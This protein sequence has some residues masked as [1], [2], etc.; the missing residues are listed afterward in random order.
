MKK[1]I[2]LVI[3]FSFLSVN[4]I[5]QDMKVNFG[6]YV[7]TYIAT[8]N[9]NSGKPW[10]GDNDGTFIPRKYTYSNIKKGQFDINIAQISANFDYKGQARGR[11]AL[12]TGSLVNT[13]YAGNSI[14]EAYA[15]FKLM[16]GL[17]IDAGY[18][19]THIGGEVYA[20]K[21]N[22]L[23]T[24]SM[25]TYFEPFFHSGI[26]ATYNS[27]K[28]TAGI[29]ILNGNGI[30]EDNNDNKSV[31]LFFGYNPTD[32]ISLSYAGIIGNEEPGSPKNAKTHMLHNICAYTKLSDNLEAKAQFDLATKEKVKL[33]GANLSDGTFMGLSAQF[34]YA[35]SQTLKSTLRFAWFNDADNVY[36]TGLDGMD[37]TI[38]LEYKPITNGYIRLEGNMLNFTE[39]TNKIGNKFI[40]ADG[41]ATNSR[42]SVMLNLGIYLD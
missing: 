25:V 36:G 28:L 41:K 10:D 23:S 24:H 5:S 15:G 13:A 21:D 35:L 22:W 2:Y 7:D 17:W 32:N 29:H 11:F 19:F 27:G 12:Q 31:G 33:D 34:R 14:Q 9:D 18:F 37:V 26:K 40:D 8:D 4:L 30:F 42:L 20:P 1:V 16:E 6:A 38:G 3:A 39:G